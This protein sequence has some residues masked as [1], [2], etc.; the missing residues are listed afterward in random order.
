MK[1]FAF[2]AVILFA[3]YA[4]ASAQNEKKPEFFAGYSFESVNSGVTSS[5]VL[6]T[7]VTQTSLDNRFNLN[8]FNVSGTAYFTKHLGITGDFSAHF[9]TRTDFFDTVATQSKF[10][11]YNI[12]VGPQ[13]KFAGSTRF[14]PFAH[15]LFGI[16]HR[17]LQET[18]ASGSDD[19]TD[20]TTS[21]AMNLG[22]GVDY[23]LNDRVSV[24]LFQFDYNPIFLRSRTSD[25]IAFPDH[26]LNGVRLSA[27]IV[28]K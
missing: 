15:A 4:L 5:D 3:S 10:R 17:N 6:A 28:I 18:V 21:F 1:R 14:T 24:R 2:L 25:S 22:G 13:Y 12:T 26:T 7:G 19:F 16:A 20:R 8:G 9:D 23:K 11:L 27:G